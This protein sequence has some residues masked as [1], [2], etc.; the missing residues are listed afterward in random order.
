MKRTYLLLMCLIPLIVKAQNLEFLFED[1]DKISMRNSIR[2]Y[3]YDKNKVEALDN[4]FSKLENGNRFAWLV[5]V[6]IF[7]IDTA[8]KDLHIYCIK[9]AAFNGDDYSKYQLAGWYRKG[10]KLERN[11]KYSLRLL[12]S[13]VEKDFPPSITALGYMYFKGFGVEQDYTRAL[14]LFKKAVDLNQ[15]AAFHLLGYFYE[16]GYAVEKDINKAIELYKRAANSGYIQSIT[17]LEILNNSLKS[18]RNQENVVKRKLSYK[19]ATKRSSIDGKIN[20]S[21]NATIYVYDWS[22]KNIIK[23]IENVMDIEINDNNFSV[24]FNS[25][26]SSI[27][28]CVGEINNN[29]LRFKDSYFNYQS[30][31]GGKDNILIES[32][33]LTS[34]VNNELFGE[35]KLTSKEAKEEFN[36]CVIS[37]KHTEKIIENKKKETLVLFPNPV[38]DKLEIK[39]SLLKIKPIKCSIYSISGILIK[40]KNYD[41]AES[42]GIIS[43]NTS[44]LKSGHY[45]LKFNDINKKFVKK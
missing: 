28:K 34:K 31:Y 37:L 13:A 12:E 29:L 19:E 35:L 45:I 9:E 44:D 2:D 3:M 25:P 23:C 5:F 36:P 26:G 16:H 24:K 20:G 32:L 1:I 41:V 43:I 15:V 21:Y 4:V 7:K 14:D 18:S 39:Y 17:R 22:K 38:N 40:T 6:N 33:K 8:Y 10:K 27:N 11:Y 30:A 42:E